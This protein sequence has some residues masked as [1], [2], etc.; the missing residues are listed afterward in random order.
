MARPGKESGESAD[1]VI[2]DV[3]WR[4]LSTKPVSKISVSEIIREAGCN[5]TTF[6][7]YY[8][9]IY[10]LA[11][12]AIRKNLPENIPRMALKFISGDIDSISIDKETEESIKRLCVIIRYSESAELTRLIENTIVD[13]WLSIFEIER[14]KAGPDILCPL[15][16]LAGGIVSVIARYAST[17]SDESIMACFRLIN[18]LFT[19]KTV[20]YVMSVNPSSH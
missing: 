18:R 2:E 5:R 1:K 20:E 14:V 9:D 11:N 8:K 16:F 6:Y 4:L 19:E 10:A 17:F 7:Y 3:F 12:S 15:E 13:M